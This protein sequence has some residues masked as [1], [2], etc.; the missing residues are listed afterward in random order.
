MSSIS[1]RIWV[2]R[3]SRPRGTRSPG[4]VTSTSLRAYSAS[5]SLALDRRLALLDGRLEPLADAVQQHPA[6]AVADA[7][8][9]LGELALAAEEAD[10]RLVELGLGPKRPAIAL[11]ASVS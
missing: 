1:R 8:Q 7:A 5:S 4:S 3:C 11:C 2:S 6:L 9:G 10:A